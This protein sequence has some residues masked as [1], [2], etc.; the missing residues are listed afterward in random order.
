MPYRS[1]RPK[2]VR[3]KRRYKGRKMG[4]KKSIRLS[5]KNLKKDVRKIRRLAEGDMGV[6]LYRERFSNQQLLT[7]DNNNLTAS[8]NLCANT[9]IGRAIDQLQMFD[10]QQPNVLVPVDLDAATFQ[11]KIW[12]SV[13]TICTFRNN[14]SV[15][16]YLDAYIC[17]PKYGHSI[18]PFTAYQNGIVDQSPQVHT[19][20]IIYPLDSI[21]FKS[22]WHVRKRK[23]IF[24]ETGRQC[25]LSDRF[26]QFSYNPSEQDEVGDIFVPKHCGYALLVRIEGCLSH[27]DTTINQVGGGHAGIDIFRTTTI[28]VSYPAGMALDRVFVDNESDAMTSQPEISNKPAAQTQ[29]FTP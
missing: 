11:N 7:T 2:R 8:Y 17:T 5:I 16:V 27:D 23:K 29:V 12:M 18:T 19:S 10:L 1:R 20:S 26:K 25:E 14:F 22:L 3:R 4:V 28:K 24:L 6:Q 21:L 9:A 13:S 15:P